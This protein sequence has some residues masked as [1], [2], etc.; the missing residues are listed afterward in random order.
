MS[1]ILGKRPMIL[2]TVGTQLPF[3]RLVKAVDE[4]APSLNE[5]IFGQIGKE[6][7]RPKNLEYCEE[8]APREFERRLGLARVILSHAGIG[9]MLTARRIGKPIILFPR[10]AKFGEHRNDHQIATS[11]QMEGRP[12]IY[13]AYDTIQ[14][15]AMMR[16][17]R[18]DAP[19]SVDESPNRAKLIKKLQHLMALNK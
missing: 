16:A 12:G 17:D 13:V 9:T 15:E 3:D 10:Q 4:I 14:M 1:G 5:E 19:L 7:Y 2:L 11:K 8:M 18:L 6:G